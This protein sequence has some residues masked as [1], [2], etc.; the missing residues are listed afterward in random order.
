MKQLM[1]CAL[2][3]AGLAY[4]QT[5]AIE[6]QKFYGGTKDDDVISI[7]QTSDG[8]YIFIGDSDSN[9]GDLTSNNGKKDFWVV[10]SNPLG[11]IQWQRSLGGSQDEEAHS[12]RQTADGGYIIAGETN[13]NDGDVTGNHGGTDAWI[14]KLNQN[15]DLVWQKTYGGSNSDSANFIEPTG[16]GGYIVAGDSNSNNGDLT[17][18]KGSYDAWVFKISSD[19]TLEWQKNYGGTAYEGAEY[20]QNTSDGGYIVAATTTSNNGDLT[21]NHGD[22]DYWFIKLNSAGNI[23]WQKSLGGTNSDYGRFSQPTL[24]GGYIV[25]GYSNSN[26]GNV[27]GNNGGFDCWIAKLNETGTIEWQKSLGGMG[28][29]WGRSLTET[30]DGGFVIALGSKSTNISAGTHHG[31]NDVLLIKLERNGSLSTS[32]TSLKKD[33]TVAPN[34]SNGYFTINHLFNNSSLEVYSLTGKLIQ[35]VKNISGKSYSIDIS[36]QPTGAYIIRI[37]NLIT[38]K[39][40]KK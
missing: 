6:W 17:Q 37:D 3:I 13:S 18:N 4:G 9:N 30:E 23:E 7:R 10:K 5:P 16:D 20:I 8:G 19:G 21:S 31:N 35:K 40:I 25:A 34:P 15:G 12:I 1:L 33:S 39:L 29:D 11:A 14:V 22:F 38:L 24:D 32:E 26:N 28:Y 27:S 2:A 36:N